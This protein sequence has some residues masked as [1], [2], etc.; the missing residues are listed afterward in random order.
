M[1]QSS[2]SSPVSTASAA[3]LLEQL[4]ACEERQLRLSRIRTIAVCALSVFI[5]AGLLTVLPSLYSVLGNL[6]SVSAQLS[7]V[8]FE[9]LAENVDA[10][11]IQA[12]I[13]LE[14]MASDMANTLASAKAALD[15]VQKINFQELNEAISDLSSIVAPLAKLFGPR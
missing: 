10:L 15:G 11:T 12:S 13:G 5:A 1:D 8:D 6:R 3:E 4:H 9:S 14:A 7:A 2:A